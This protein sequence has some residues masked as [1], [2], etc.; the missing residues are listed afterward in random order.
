[1][2]IVNSGSTTMS[3]ANEIWTQLR[4]LFT[5]LFTEF[6]LELP[7][8]RERAMPDKM[9]K[10]LYSLPADRLRCRRP[11]GGE[12]PR[13]EVQVRNA[14][15]SYLAHYGSRR[16]IDCYLRKEGCMRNRIATIAA[17]AAV[18][19]GAHRTGAAQQNVP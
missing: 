17:V 1:C 14:V 8:I 12:P 9:N 2:S 4:V 5:T 19:V 3:C 18:L 6:V 15:P 16:Q 10:S 7:T 13:R 11:E